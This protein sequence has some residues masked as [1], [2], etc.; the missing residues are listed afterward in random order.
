MLIEWTF[1][2]DVLIICQIEARQRFL[3]YQIATGSWPVNQH[4][5]H[6]IDLLMG[7]WPPSH[8]AESTTISYVP[9]RLAVSEN[10]PEFDWAN[11]ILYLF[12]CLKKFWLPLFSR[13]K[14]FKAKNE[15]QYSI[16]QQKQI[17]ICLEETLRRCW[18][19]FVPTVSAKRKHNS[20]ICGRQRDRLF[21][22]WISKRP[23]SVPFY[24]IRNCLALS[25]CRLINFTVVE[26]GDISQ[27]RITHFRI[28]FFSVNYFIHFSQI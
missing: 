15:S 25:V 5:N 9:V 3:P 10:T 14:S 12:R 27:I 11:G 7:Q 23:S 13:V 20:D 24:G 6:W 26:L 19:W 28:H 2:T 18:C 1:F 4:H 22:Y 17:W 21:Y 16:S 8:H